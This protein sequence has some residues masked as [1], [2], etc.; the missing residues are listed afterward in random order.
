MGQWCLLHSVCLTNPLTRYPL[1]G[2]CSA[3]SSLLLSLSSTTSSEEDHDPLHTPTLSQGNLTSGESDDSAGYHTHSITR[4]TTLPW[5]RMRSPQMYGRPLMS[6]GAFQL[7]GEVPPD[8]ASLSQSGLTGDSAEDEVS[9]MGGASCEPSQTP[10]DELTNTVP[11]D[12]DLEP[13]TGRS[14][15][16][17]NLSRATAF[18]TWFQS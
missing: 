16:C 17:C 18:W 9:V 15:R 12:A 13:N 6:G 4:L 7:P 10:S 14:R 2:C 3:Q 8:P 5:N 1:S 11:V